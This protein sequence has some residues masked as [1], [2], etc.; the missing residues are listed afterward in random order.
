MELSEKDV[1]QLQS[2]LAVVNYIGAKDKKAEKIPKPKR[3]SSTKFTAKAENKAVHSNTN[4][5]R[6]NI[7]FNVSCF[8]CGGKH[9]ANKCTLDRNIKCNSCGT[10]GH[11][12]K[13][14]MGGKRAST[15][16]FGSTTFRTHRFQR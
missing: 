15:N 5:S 8:R 9:L 12:Q 4:K 7:G 14:C 10:P 13:V 2:G 6:V 1:Q 16:Q 11:L 3:K